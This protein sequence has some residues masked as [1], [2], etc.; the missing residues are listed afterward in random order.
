M[1][2]IL[3][4]KSGKRKPRDIWPKKIYFDNDKG[5]QCEGGV[6][7][8][9]DISKNLVLF[10]SRDLYF[11]L[12]G[13]LPWNRPYWFWIGNGCDICWKHQILRFYLFITFGGGV[14]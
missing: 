5:L 1:Y 4:V 3:I 12:L 14:L 10:I 7:K 11:G 2:V 6:N 13:D 9:F 8:P